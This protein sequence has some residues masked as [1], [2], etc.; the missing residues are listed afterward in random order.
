M[1]FFVEDEQVIEE[2]DVNIVVEWKGILAEGVKWLR[3]QY[4]ENN[5]RFINCTESPI[6]SV[7]SMIA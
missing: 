5:K 1:V 2:A 7:L 3:K 6:C 4:C